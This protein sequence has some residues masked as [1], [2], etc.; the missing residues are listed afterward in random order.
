MQKRRL[1]TPDEETE[2]VRLSEIDSMSLEDIA[3]KLNRTRE[4]CRIKLQNI[5][6]RDGEAHVK[7]VLAMSLKEYNDLIK[8]AEAGKRITQV[9]AFAD[10]N[11][12]DYKSLYV[13]C[14]K[15]INAYSNHRN[16]KPFFEELSAE[17][18]VRFPCPY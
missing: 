11:Y 1:W 17:M 9:K 5:R 15:L 10:S 8:D 12:N 18:E 14:E 2:L 16:M 6:K 13:L 3:A 7:F 4:A